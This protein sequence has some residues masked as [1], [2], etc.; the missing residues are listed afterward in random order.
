MSYVSR[1]RIGRSQY[2]PPVSERSLY[3]ET[4]V[5]GSLDRLWARTQD[6]AQHARWDLRF[7]EIVHLP[8]TAGD[9]QRFRYA[10]R[11]AGPTVS[12]VG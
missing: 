3:V 5:H 4:Y 2:A 9:P 10:V 12:G 8:T 7:T 1:Q 11:L 6:P